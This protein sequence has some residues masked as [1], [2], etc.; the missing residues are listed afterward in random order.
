MKAAV[1]SAPRGFS[2]AL[3]IGALHFLSFG[4]GVFASRG[5]LFGDL[6]PFSMALTA[7]LPREYCATAAAGAI[8]GVLYPAS[9]GYSLRYIGALV[10]IVLAKWILTELLHPASDAVING[11]IGAVGAVFT[12]VL[13]AIAT[14][15]DTTVLLHYFAESL[16]AGIGAYFISQV[17]GMLS[18]GRKTGRLSTEELCAVLFSVAMFLSVFS[19]FKIAF[20]TPASVVSSVIIL[21]A[22]RFG[23]E[24]TGTLAGVILGFFMGAASG[25]LIVM[26]GACALGG[27]VGG[28]LSKYGS[29]FTVLGY[30]FCNILMLFT[31]TETSSIQYS[32]FETLLASLLFLTLPRKLSRTASA[33]FSPAPNLARVDGLRKSLVMR[34]KFAS[35]ALTDV[36]GTVDEVS[37]RLRQVNTPNLA[38]VLQ[39]VERECC[40]KCGLRIYCYETAK[41]DTY[42]AL[43]Q[44]TKSIRRQGYAPQDIFPARWRERCCHP[45]EVALSLTKHFSSYMQQ[46]DAN[47]RI[48][49]IRSVV[50]DQMGGLSDM[51]YDMAQDF[52]KGERYDTETAARIDTVL[53]SNGLAATDI[54]CRLDTAGRMSIEICADATGLRPINKQTLCDHISRVCMRQFSLPCVSGCGG[55]MLLN[56]TEQSNY[57]VEYGAA[58]SNCGNEKLCGDTWTVFDD[59][60]GKTVMLISDGMGCGGRAAVDS[61]MAS[62]L[63]RRLVQAGFGFE[64]SLKLLNSAMCLKSTDESMATLDIAT[65]DLFSGQVVFYKAGAPE[66]LVRHGKKIGRAL[67]TSFP[68]GILREVSF[69]CTSVKL[70]DRDIIVMMSDGVTDTAWI[71]SFLRE[72]SRGSAQDL[73]EELADAARRRRNDGHEDDIT[74]LVG[75]IKRQTTVDS[76]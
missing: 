43:M 45:D 7:G 34:L 18:L 8:L 65:I 56:M 3:R 50:A 47:R 41:E 28:L 26:T 44:M 16:F 38:D 17:I 20:L 11:G 48:G 37:D 9:G 29:I 25:E 49:E 70:Y 73:A 5:I 52:D 61:A 71:D 39:A 19:S 21:C 51:L 22:A 67:C 24:Q 27:L 74:V 62:G 14:Q 54:A 59:G 58:Q 55:H 1:Q 76:H 66:S 32:I 42:N 53:R 33:F 64:A 69:E 36:S 46:Q 2:H 35:E 63:M 40:S 15:P 4:G 68:A 10:L 13:T 6:M 60:R 72:F 12:G 23:A 57:R 75:I 30:I 31:V